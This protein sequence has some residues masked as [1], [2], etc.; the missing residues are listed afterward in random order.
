[1]ASTNASITPSS[2]QLTARLRTDFRLKAAAV[3][4]RRSCIT[5]PPSCTRLLPGDP[6][7]LDRLIP[8]RFNN[9]SSYKSAPPALPS[10]SDPRCR[11]GIRVVDGRADSGRVLVTAADGRGPIVL[12]AEAVGSM[13]EYVDVGDRSP[14]RND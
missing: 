6:L 14:T 2:R 11:L 9:L 10:L 7:L 1:M 5:A 12:E 4:P 8:T 13:T 3:N